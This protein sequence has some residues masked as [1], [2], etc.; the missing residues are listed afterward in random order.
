MLG[1]PLISINGNFILFL[2]LNILLEWFLLY[3]SSGR[4]SFKNKFQ[5]GFISMIRK[6]KNARERIINS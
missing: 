3:N 2:D 4:S 6:Q 5:Q 1:T